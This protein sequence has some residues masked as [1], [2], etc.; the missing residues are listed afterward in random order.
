L[1]RIPESLA[2]ALLDLEIEGRVVRDR[3]GRFRLVP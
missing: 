2:L 3:D 1:G